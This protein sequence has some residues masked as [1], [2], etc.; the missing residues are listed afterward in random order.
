MGSIDTNLAADVTEFA[1]SVKR[2][3]EHAFRALRETEM[4]AAAT[5]LGCLS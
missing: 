1:A 2:D 5:V 3:A 4:R